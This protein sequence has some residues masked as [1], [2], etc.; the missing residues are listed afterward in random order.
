MK[1]YKIDNNIL[2]VL[3][4]ILILV[5]SVI[6]HSTHFKLF[7]S[8]VNLLGKDFKEQFEHHSSPKITDKSEKYSIVRLDYS[9]IENTTGHFLK[10]VNTE[11]NDVLDYQSYRTADDLSGIIYEVLLL[12]LFNQCA[13]FNYTDCIVKSIGL[14]APP[15]VY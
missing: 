3:A 1:R 13:V 12:S 2:F 14:R 6:P 10:K 9:K 15:F 11:K 4:G 7:S 5:H 8:T